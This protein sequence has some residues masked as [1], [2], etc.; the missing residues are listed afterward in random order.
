MRLDSK[1][2]IWILLKIESDRRQVFD[3]YIKLEQYYDHYCHLWCLA[4]CGAQL[5]SLAHVERT[6]ETDFLV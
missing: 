1:N 4:Q 5:H 3:N 2:Y 6:S